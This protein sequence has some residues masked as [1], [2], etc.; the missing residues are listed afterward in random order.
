[1]HVGGSAF[2]IWAL[3]KKGNTMNGKYKG[4]VYAY[5]E[6]PSA[7]D[8]GKAN[9]GCWVVVVFGEYGSVGEDLEAFDTKAEAD[10]FARSMEQ[11]WH[12]AFS[13]I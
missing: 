9:T 8:F 11:E 1:M 12:P 7:R 13:G 6:S 10:A 2:R 4:V 5:P 3:G